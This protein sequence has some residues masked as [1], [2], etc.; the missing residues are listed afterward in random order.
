MDKIIASAKEL[1][2][3]INAGEKSSVQIEGS[4]SRVVSVP[5]DNNDNHPMHFIIKL[6]ATGDDISVSS[7]DADTIALIKASENSSNV[8]VVTGIPAS[9]NNY[10]EIKGAKAKDSGVAS[11][12]KAKPAY[13]QGDVTMKF[14][15]EIVDKNVT[16][17]TCLAILND[18]IFS[19]KDFWAWPA[20]KRN[21][22][23]AIG[24]LAYHSLGVCMT[25]MKISAN[26][27]YQNIDKSILI[28]GALIHDIGKL[29]EYQQDGTY[30]DEYGT[31]LG[32]TVIGEM[33]LEDEANKLGLSFDDLTIRQLAHI[34]AS[35][36]G[37]REKGA[38]AVP[39]TMEAVI[40]Y[41]SDDIDATEDACVTAMAQ[42]V[43]YGESTSPIKM[44]GQD[45]NR[46]IR[47]H[48]AQE[49]PAEAKADAP[50]EKQSSESDVPF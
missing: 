46:L 30:V 49:A 45:E 23:A 27:N 13:P 42:T 34:I 31:L 14:V 17:P 35:H 22:H 5:K 48:P 12:R 43:S 2:A 39:A 8:F 4:I 20:A 15:K 28:T 37:T 32:H 6:E 11:K 9:Y 19:S 33:M 7:W 47:M 10:P 1:Q 44:L 40:V 18:L 3:A 16:D 25:A 41:K 50:E 21:H 24:G 38:A 29:K 26:Y 36:H